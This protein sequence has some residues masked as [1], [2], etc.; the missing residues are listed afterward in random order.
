MGETLKVEGETRLAATLKIAGNRLRDWSDPG[1]ETASFV[2][3]RGRS[4]APHRT[5]RLASSIRS[6]VDAENAEVV[7]GLPYANR[8]HWGY[9]R[10]SQP[11]QP[12][13][14]DAVWDNGRLIVDK[15]RDRADLVLH[16][17]KGA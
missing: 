12:F 1:R 4:D 14:A 11:A 15:Y 9:R 3:G 2:A 6:S 16:G 17:V 13:L 10:Y 8:T 5:G 7:S